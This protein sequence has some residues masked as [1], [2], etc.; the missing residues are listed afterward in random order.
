[1]GNRLF[2]TKIQR[3]SIHDGPGIRMTVF[4]K[5]CNLACRWCHNP[6][7]QHASQEIQYLESRC[8]FCGICVGLCPTEAITIKDNWRLERKKCTQCQKCVSHC[9]AGALQTVGEYVDTDTILEKALE[10]VQLFGKGGITFSGGEP[11][12]QAGELKA[13]LRKAK[14]KGMHTAVDTAGNVDWECFRE[15]LSYTD[16]FLYDVKTVDRK[17]HRDYTGV[18]NQIILRNLKKL[19]ALEK[20]R[21]W[22]RMPIIHGLNDRDEDIG[23]FLDYYQELRKIERIDLLPYHAYGTYKA[24]SLCMKEEKFEAPSKE[25][26]ESLLTQIREIN[27]NTHIL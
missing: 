26:M 1:M 27:E 16:L 4:L 13:A 18:D 20:G 14:E 24:K 25:R 12:L 9:Y 22:I 6:E 23:R 11:L 3:F 5:G 17:A 7:T 2:I 15:I 10:D 8:R 21:V 19:S